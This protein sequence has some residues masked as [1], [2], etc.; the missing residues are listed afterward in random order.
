VQKLGQLK[1]LSVPFLAAAV[2]LVLDASAARANTYTEITN[3]T[4]NGNI[5]SNLISTFPTGTYTPTN[6]VDGVTGNNFGA[7]FS[8]GTGTTNFEQIYV[9]PLTITTDVAH[10]TNV[11]T[12]INGYSPA[13]TLG[14]IEFVGSGGATQT[15][16]LV[17]N[18]NVRDFYNGVYANNL[19][20]PPVPGS[21]AAVA[22]QCSTPSCSGGGGTGDV[23]TGASGTYRLDEQDFVLNSSFASQDL[24]EIIITNSGGTNGDSVPILLGVTAADISSTPLPAAL[25]LFGAGL[26]ALGLLGWRRKRKNAAA[27]A[28]A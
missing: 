26:G 13:G 23:T 20:S 28:A 8:I 14:T 9:G 27:L 12:L 6:G 7:P 16:S 21:S 15:F 3:F 10:V 22:F 11:F 18:G 5:Q 17:S 4:T 25:P 24:V 1:A 2:A 19:N